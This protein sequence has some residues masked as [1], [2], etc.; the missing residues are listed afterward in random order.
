MAADDGKEAHATPKP[1]LLEEVQQGSRRHMPD[2][3]KK[4]KKLMR[5]AMNDGQTSM[6]ITRDAVSRTFKDASA[7][8]IQYLQDEGF[9]VEDTRICTDPGFLW[10]DAVVEPGYLISWVV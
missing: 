9:V 4:W 6:K 3:H 1:S 5:T 10:E 8:A 7:A 2:F